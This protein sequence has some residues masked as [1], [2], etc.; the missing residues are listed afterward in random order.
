MAHEVNGVPVAI[1][2]LKVEQLQAISDCLMGKRQVRMSAEQTWT[3]E[4]QM[5]LI[6]IINAELA[7][8]KAEHALKN[9][10]LSY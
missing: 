7:L 1:F 4:N 2:P 9:K 6:E 3:A 8:L 5:D 10:I